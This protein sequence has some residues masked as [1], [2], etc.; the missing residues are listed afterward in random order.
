MF[1]FSGSTMLAFASGSAF[2]S[3]IVRGKMVI[4]FLKEWTVLKA[5]P[6]RFHEWRWMGWRR[7]HIGRDRWLW[8]A[9]WRW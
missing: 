6:F 3:F 2:Q 5:L 9:S 4:L 1:G 7:F 8:M